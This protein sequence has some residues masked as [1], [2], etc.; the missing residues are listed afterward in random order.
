LAKN[1]DP[2]GKI[3]AVKVLMTL[4]GHILSFLYFEGLEGKQ[5][6]L[7][8]DGYQRDERAEQNCINCHYHAATKSIP[9]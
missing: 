6:V 9:L 8:K 2:E 3:R 4:S 5:F 1:P 7:I